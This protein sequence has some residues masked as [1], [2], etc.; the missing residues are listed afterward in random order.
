M[1]AT[2]S[3]QNW[4][5]YFE[6]NKFFPW[7]FYSHSCLVVYWANKNQ[8]EAIFYSSHSNLAVSDSVEGLVDGF[9]RTCSK[10]SG[11]IVASIYEQMRPWS[12]LQKW[13]WTSWRHND[14]FHAVS[15]VPGCY[16]CIICSSDADWVC[17]PITPY[18]N[19]HQSKK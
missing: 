1:R 14:W 6:R 12:P 7:K 9:F 18:G 16:M 3:L 10:H 11:V 4:E 2:S 19:L 8:E 15:E 5:E 17:L 13:F